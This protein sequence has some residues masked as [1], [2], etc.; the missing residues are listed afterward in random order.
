MRKNK[1]VKNA[2]AELAAAKESWSALR[3][4]PSSTATQRLDAKGRYNRAMR[5]LA[6]AHGTR[7]PYG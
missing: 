5:D 2:E 7:A 4:D 6:F 1:Q 3:Q